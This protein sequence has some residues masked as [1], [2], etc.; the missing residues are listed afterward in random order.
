M[1]AWHPEQ[2]NVD[3]RVRGRDGRLYPARMASDAER[4]RVVRL[5]HTL[6][7]MDQLSVRAVQEHLE[8][9]HGI[10]RS[11]GA[12]AADLKRWRCEYCRAP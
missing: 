6:R 4:F 10:R 5:V 3:V 9:E 2:V 11:V 12:I 7:C 8:A 1:A